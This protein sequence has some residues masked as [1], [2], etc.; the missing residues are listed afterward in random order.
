MNETNLSFDDVVQ[1]LRGNVREPCPRCASGYFDI[2]SE[3][4]GETLKV[5]SIKSENSDDYVP[6]FLVAC[7]QCGNVQLFLRDLIASTFASGG[8]HHG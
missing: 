3:E 5:Y 2:L 7:K 1:H 4:D 8:N 6:V